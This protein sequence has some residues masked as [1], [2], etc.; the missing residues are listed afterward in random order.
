MGD[1]PLHHLVVADHR[2]RGHPEPHQTVL[3]LDVGHQAEDGRAAGGGGLVGAEGADERGLVLRFRVRGEAVG[4]DEDAAGVLDPR[5]AEVLGGP[6]VA[7]RTGERGARKS[8]RNTT[9][10]SLTG[11]SRPLTTSF[12]QLLYWTKADEIKFLADVSVFRKGRQNLCLVFVPPAGFRTQFGTIISSGRRPAAPHGSEV[13][14]TKENTSADR[15]EI[16]A[17]LVHGE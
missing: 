1:E 6:A 13:K 11:E 12:G 9:W 4:D 14:R 17:M 3:A 15:T 2:G 16:D 8:R 7:V 10:A 5:A